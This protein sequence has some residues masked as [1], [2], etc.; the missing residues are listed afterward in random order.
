MRLRCRIEVRRAVLLALTAVLLPLLHAAPVHAAPRCADVFP[1]SFAERLARDF[2]GQRVT[3]SVHDTRTGCWYSLHGGMRITSASV[4]KAGV[5][6]GVLLRAQDAGRRLTEAERARIR[7]MVH[8]SHNSPYVSWLYDRAGGVAGMDAA[9]RRWGARATTNTRAF[10]ATWTTAEDRTRVALGLLQG[11]GP[12]SPAYRAEAWRYLS[13]V[14]PTQR[15]GISAGLPAGWSVA[16]KNGFYPMRGYGWRAGSS[17]FA[18]ADYGGG[19]AITVLTDGA[20][21]QWQGMRLVETVS[22]RV[23]ALL[24]GGSPAPRPF[25]RAVCTA[26]RSGESWTAV[27]RRLG[28]DPAGVRS[29]S[30]GNRSPLQGQRA[31]S[32]ALRG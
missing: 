10:G 5:L 15:W 25:E 2:P 6:G 9:D 31:C 11:P 17:G 8:L 16:L 13:S 3:A 1:A 30:G 7:P 24:A 28:A 26:T 18:H 21:S 4:I 14:H 27:A 29:V 19:Y 22:R 23:A 32:P 12:L 20:A